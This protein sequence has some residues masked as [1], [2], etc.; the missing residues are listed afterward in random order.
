MSDTAETAIIADGIVAKA[1]SKFSSRKF[2][3]ALLVILIGT[4]LTVW[5]KLTSEHLVDLLK[6][7][8]GMYLGFNVTQ[9]ASEWIAG[10]LGS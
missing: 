2:S 7:I 6:W 5:G 1:E 9:K 8:T 4:A 10:K 3:L